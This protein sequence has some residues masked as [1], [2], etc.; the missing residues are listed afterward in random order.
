MQSAGSQSAS[1]TSGS[2]HQ[3]AQNRS[4]SGGPAAFGQNL[5]VSVGYASPASSAVLIQQLESPTGFFN[6]KT[7]VSEIK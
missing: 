5:P 6:Y 7:K 2:C 4:P 3:P 1:A